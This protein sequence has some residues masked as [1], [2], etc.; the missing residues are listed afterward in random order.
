MK[1]KDF[2]EDFEEPST[3]VSRVSS[4]LYQFQWITFTLQGLVAVSV[5]SPLLALLAPLGVAVPFAVAAAVV[6]V[7]FA[8]RVRK[9][10]FPRSLPKEASLLLD[11][12]LKCK[13]RFT[14]L[15]ELRLE[16]ED[17]EAEARYTVISRQLSPYLKEINVKELVPFVLPKRLRHGLYLSPVTW[18][19]ALILLFTQGTALPPEVAKLEEVL[20]K[21][22]LPAQ[23]KEALE[24]LKETVL[25]KGLDSAEAREAVKDALDSIEQ[26]KKGEALSAQEKKGEVAE[27]RKE[28]ERSEKGQA[29]STPTPVSVVEQE[30]KKGKKGE[31]KD[32]KGDAQL[33]EKEVQEKTQRQKEKEGDGKEEK[34]SE[35]GE[36]EGQKPGGQGEGEQNQPGGDKG[37]QGQQGSQQNQQGEGQSQGGQ[38]QQGEQQQQGEGQ[39]QGE[40]QE[41]GT[42]QEKQGGQAG[43]S[44]GGQKSGLDAAK[45]AVEG[46]KEQQ[47]GQGSS[48]EKQENDKSSP[49]KQGKGSANSGSGENKSGEKEKKDQQDEKKGAGKPG[50]GKADESKK[51]DAAKEKGDG[52]STGDRTRPSDSPDARRFMEEGEEG[53]EGLQGEKGF[54]DAVIEGGEELLDTRFTEKKGQTVKNEQEAKFKTELGELSLEKPDPVKQRKTQQ[55]PLEYKDLL[56]R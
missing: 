52:G 10:N 21:E 25:E 24:Q 9:G 37:D 23:V 14:A 49:N 13:E 46:V 4:R 29:L 8:I 6:L 47:E 32:G 22:E 31:V 40:G 2:K 43:G 42:P 17:P 53:G 44:Q 3:L 12:Q 41:G 55:I 54:K 1:E 35:G 30:K 27:K 36:G 34:E 16:K 11:D 38:G 45:E 48:G 7:M 51:G 18:V 15:E 5:V 26:E 39:S 28:E 50:P 56:S 19:I 33:Q 20:K